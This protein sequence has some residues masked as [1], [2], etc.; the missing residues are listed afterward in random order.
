MRR[1]RELVGVSPGS[2]LPARAASVGEATRSSSSPGWRGWSLGDG[3]GEALATIGALEI[4]ASDE[5]DADEVGRA[6]ERRRD[7][8]RAE[9]ER[10]EG[11]LANE[12]FVAKAPPEVVEEEREKLEATGPSSR[13]FGEGDRCPPGEPRGGSEAVRGD[14][15]AEDWLGLEPVGWRFGLERMQAA[16]SL[17]MPQRRYARS[18]S[19]APT[20]SRR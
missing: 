5:I 2:V 18:T 12:G 3:E 9:V 4:L 6:S 11:K 17:G 7:E 19:S 16:R 14:F 1:W 10:A 13:S 20:A 8:L 15:A